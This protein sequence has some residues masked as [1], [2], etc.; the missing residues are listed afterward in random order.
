[1]WV[2]SRQFTG[3]IV[4]VANSRIFDEPVYNYTREF[5]FIW[6]E[7]NIPVSYKDDRKTAEE[8]IIRAAEN[9]TREFMEM[10]ED[11]RHRLEHRYHIHTDDTAP[12]VYYRLTDNWIDL[13][14]RFLVREHGVRVV[15][16]RMSREIIEQ[17]DAHKIG[18]ASGTY[19]IVGLPPVTVRLTADTDRSKTPQ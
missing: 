3:R 8:I 13:T 4:T 2:K 6:E 16:D 5:P 10:S 17:F 11:E 7:M 12:H 1:M 15:K 9:A 14:V 19:D 18:I